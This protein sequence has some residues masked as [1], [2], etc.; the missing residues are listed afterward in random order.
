[1]ISN[2]VKIA[3]RNLL[4]HKSISFIMIFGL[5][6]S[7][8]AYLIIIQYVISEFSFDNFHTKADDIYRI[9]LDDYKNNVLSTSSAISYYAAGPAIKDAL[10][11]VDNFVR[12]HRADGMVSH[13][14]KIG[15]LVSYHEKKAFYADSSFFSVF[16]VP[17]LR[18]A[19]N[20]VL[21]RPESVVLSESMARKYF[22]QDN[23]LGKIIQLSTEWEG[24][25]Y[26]VEGVFADLPY[27]SHIQIDFLFSIQKLLR[28]QQFLYGGWYW[29]NFYTYLLLKPGSSPKTLEARFADI[30]QQHLGSQLK[31][32][33]LQQRFVLQPLRSIH[34]YSRIVSEVEANGKIEIVYGLLLVAFFILAIGWLNY[35]NLSTAKGIERA[36]EVGIR[37]ALGSQKG[38]LIGQFLFESLT[39][40]SLSVLLAAGLFLIALAFFDSW[41]H[42]GI[43]FNVVQQ[44]LFWV[45]AVSIFLVGFV[46][47]GFYPAF[48]LSSFSPIAV[49]KGRLS[50]QIGGESFRK[51]LIVFQFTASIGL[52]IATLVIN[53]QIKFMQTQDLGIH[54]DQKLIV[55]APKVL[56][57]N[58]FTNDIGYF[59]D[60]LAASSSV[61]QVTASSEV[62]GQEIFWTNDFQ[63]YP[64]PTNNYKRCSLLAVDEDYI[65]TYRIELLAGRD[66]YK[67]LAR[68]N[69]AIIINQTALRAFGFTTP[70]EAINQQLADGGHSP[71]TVIGVV[72]DFHQQS[73]DTSNRPI[74]LQHLPWESDYLTIQLS[75]TSLSN[76]V[77]TIQKAFQEAFPANAFESFFLDTHFQQQYQSD[78]VLASLLSWFSFLAIGIASLGLLGLAMFTATNRTKEIGIRKVMGASVGNVIV[79]LSKDFLKLVI[80]AIFLASPLAW[81]VMNRWLQEF[82]Y[83]TT[84]SWWIF[85]SAAILA[86]SIALLTVSFHSIKAAL[87]NP[88]KSLKS[89]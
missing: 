71:K 63:R 54:I 10:P 47:S 6:S 12:L 74:I 67:D 22:G 56:R 59:K 35:I 15:E 38:Q 34:L 41:V 7:M 37:K 89:E 2:Y 73:L 76:S 3:W 60:R 4:K 82:A 23:P 13:H 75:G 80:I 66:F 21:H 48:I 27:N 42:T 57:T 58:S 17:L 78:E 50:K 79:L 62:P 69:N 85:A 29:T 28:N 65:S 61:K 52:V 55:K 45:A 32:Y 39:I 36:K 26:V 16:S 84:L 51:A 33:N 83:K 72:K 1:M 25:N 19:A 70:Q 31:K 5:A 44:P 77:A 49:L 20:Q 40:N 8:A 18:T 30:I 86:V 87:M 53:R 81:Y 24:G 64:D 46:L 11:E 43:G 9:R 14:K 68:D 88:T